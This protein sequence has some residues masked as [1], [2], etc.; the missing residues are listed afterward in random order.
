M[1]HILDKREKSI[2]EY[3]K[4]GKSFHEIADKLA[5]SHHTVKAI[6]NSAQRKLK[7]QTN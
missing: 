2:L 4:E 5:I 1:M 7:T 6:L 3:H